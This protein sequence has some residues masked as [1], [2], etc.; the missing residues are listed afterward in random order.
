MSNPMS[1]D[2]MHPGVYVTVSRWHDNA[3][4]THASMRSRNG[5]SRPSTQRLYS[6]GRLWA[7]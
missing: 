3:G 1:L 6:L 4:A 2:D 7:G 5:W